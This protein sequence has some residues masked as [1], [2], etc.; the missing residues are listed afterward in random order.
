MKYVVT[1]LVLGGLG[2]VS[3]F[4]ATALFFSA[5]GLKVS[6]PWETRV[7]IWIDKRIEHDSQSDLMPRP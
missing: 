2:V 3:L 5:G 6:G 1:V 7:D 4:C